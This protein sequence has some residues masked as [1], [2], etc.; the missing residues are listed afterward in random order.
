LSA[1]AGAATGGVEDAGFE[2]ATRAVVQRLRA[3][4]AG[5]TQAFP[6]ERTQ[7]AAHLAEALGVDHVLAWKAAKIIDGED[8][9]LAAQYVP[10]ASGA[11]ILLQ[12]AQ[13]RGV[14]VR[15]LKRARAA[16]EDFREL[17]RV[18]AGTRKAFDQMVAG[19]VTHN[20]ERAELEQRRGAFERLGYLWGVQARCQVLSYLLNPSAD[21]RSFDAATLRGFSDLRRLRPKAPW[22]LGRPQ[23]I[24]DAGDL[25]STFRRVALDPV[26]EGAD[27][28]AAPPLL[29]SFCSQPLPRFLR[30]QQPNGTVEYLLEDG[31]VGNS[32]LLSCFTG[33]LLY[34]AEPRYRDERHRDLVIRAYARTPCEHFLFDLFVHR[35][36]FGVMTPELAL[37]SALFATDPSLSCQECDR[38]PHFETVESHRDVLGAALAPEAP[39]YAEMIRF[40]FERLGWDPREFD[41]YRVRVAYPPVP[42]IIVLSQPLPDPTSA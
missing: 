9:F 38:I 23:S 42:S 19:Y 21:G 27:P 12:A 31:P 25:R 4:L 15:E 24:D 35:A 13:D 30:L 7:R 6:A 17:V 20:R 36:L 41:L 8:P 1:P 34:A 14:P 11:R 16:F 33:E 37:Y 39:R 2:A 40:A 28:L 18:H 10:G 22:R 29:R 32:G 5:V 3:A 26:D